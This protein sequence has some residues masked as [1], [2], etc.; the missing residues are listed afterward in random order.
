M[1]FQFQHEI[2]VADRAGGNSA[3]SLQKLRL[4]KSRY[5]ALL[6]QSAFEPSI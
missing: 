3:N 5:F 2:N 4:P 1:L 6:M